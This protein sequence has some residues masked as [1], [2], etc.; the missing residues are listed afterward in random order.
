MSSTGSVSTRRAESVGQ[1]RGGVLWRTPPRLP[2]MAAADPQAG[3]VPETQPELNVAARSGLLVMATLLIVGLCLIVAGASVG[4]VATPADGLQAAL[5]PTNN[6]PETEAAPAPRPWLPPTREAVLTLPGPEVLAGTGHGSTGSI[7]LDPT[8]LKELLA[9]RFARRGDTAMIRHWKLLGMPAL[10]AVALAAPVSAQGTIDGKPLPPKGVE[11][12]DRTA[13]ESAS[14]RDVL[15]QLKTLGEDLKNMKDGLPQD[16]QN[17]KRD[18]DGIRK[19]LESAKSDRV[20]TDLNVTHAQQDINQLKEQLAQLRR[21]MDDL[22]RRAAA[23]PST[24]SGYAGAAAPALPTTRVRLVNTYFEP[25]TVMVNNRTYMLAPGEA[26]MTDPVPAGT[27][28]YE[29]LGVTEPR[30]R[31]LAATDTFTITV[32]PQG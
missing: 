12:A 16:F 26:R 25:M 15:A 32:H 20:T 23:A 19:E 10:L 2:G 18:M 30:T 28:S 21:D 6:K 13:G 29:V 27:F 7:R 14:M 5:P 1:A 3:L 9:N 24:I 17:I 4:N 22:R 11:P 8:F 31:T